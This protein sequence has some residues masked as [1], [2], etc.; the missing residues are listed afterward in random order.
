MGSF[1]YSEIVIG[2]VALHRTDKDGSFK[3]PVAMLTKTTNDQAMASDL[4]RMPML[5]P[6][7][8]M[9]KDSNVLLDL[10]LEKPSQGPLY[11]FILGEDQLEVAVTV[12]FN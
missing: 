10:L 1:V 7:L 9:D 8:E 12:P 6:Q 11:D 4:S 5:D 2:D 3:I